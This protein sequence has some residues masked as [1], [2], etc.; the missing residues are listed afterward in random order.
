MEPIDYSKYTME[1]LMD[2]RKELIAEIKRR[3]ENEDVIELK[4]MRNELDI[5]ISKMQFNR[6]RN[7]I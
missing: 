2:I 4:R 6:T 1:Q 7:S 3:I 5:E